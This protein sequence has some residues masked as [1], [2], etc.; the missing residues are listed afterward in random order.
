MMKKRQF[1]K[2]TWYD[3]LVHHIPEPIQRQWGLLRIKLWDF[4]KEAQPNI[5]IKMKNNPRK[6]KLHKEKNKKQSEDNMIKDV[7]NLFQVLKENEDTL[8]S[9]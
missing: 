1:T 7:R 9:F 2:N 6:P 4:L 8:N 3:L 5:I